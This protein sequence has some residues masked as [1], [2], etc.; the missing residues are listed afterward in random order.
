M[1]T[2]RFTDK[3]EVRRKTLPW[4]AFYNHQQRRSR[5]LRLAPISFEEQRHPNIGFRGAGPENRRMV[6]SSE[7]PTLGAVVGAGMV[8]RPRA[9]GASGNTLR[10][11]VAH[12]KIPND[13]AAAAPASTVAVSRTRRTAHALALTRLTVQQVPLEGVTTAMPQVTDQRHHQP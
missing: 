11:E 10:L 1:A 13:S 4:I 6:G 8:C 3:A 2:S 7:G 9:C 12:F 5:A